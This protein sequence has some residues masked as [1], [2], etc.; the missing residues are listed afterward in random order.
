MRL[1]L[2]SGTLAVSFACSDIE[3]CGDYVDYMC[4]CHSEDVS[5]DDLTQTLGTADPMVQ[6][7]CAID[8]SEQ[9]AA[10]AEEGLE[11]STF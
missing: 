5:C 11:C 7:Q 4:Q 2:M 8:L 1:L 10:D 9:Q 3:P 6:S